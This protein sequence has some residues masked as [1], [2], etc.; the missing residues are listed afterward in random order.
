[1]MPEIGK[2]YVNPL[3]GYISRVEAWPATLG[4]ERKLVR[5]RGAN[6]DFPDEGWRDYRGEFDG[7]SVHHMP[8][9]V[10]QANHVP[11]ESRPSRQLAFNL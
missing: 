5:D 2:L 6:E 3:S 10:W 9:K 1:M 7:R 4:G 11:F 8:L